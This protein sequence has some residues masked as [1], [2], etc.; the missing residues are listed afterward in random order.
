MPR[1]LSWLAAGFLAVSA[2]ISVIGAGAYVSLAGIIEAREID[3]LEAVADLKDQQIENWLQERIG[4]AKVIVND[5]FL[6]AAIGR[7]FS[8]TLDAA[9][10]RLLVQRLDVFREIYGYASI[11]LFDAA[12]LRRFSSG[13][14]RHDNLAAAHSEAM[15]QALARPLIQLIDFHRGEVADQAGIFFSLATALRSDGNPPGQAMGVLLLNIDPNSFLFPT[16]QS[17]PGSNKTGEALLVRREGEEVVFINHL[18][19]H[20]AQPLTL[21]LPARLDL[22]ATKALNGATGWVNGKDYRGVPVTAALRQIAATP[23]SL[24]V[25]VDDEEIFHDVRLLAGATIGAVLF[26]IVGTAIFVVLLWR[27]QRLADVLA[28]TEKDSVF[29]SVIDNA[30]DA[31]CIAAPD[32]HY[33]YANKEAT[34][35]LGYSQAELLVMRVGDITPAADRAHALSRFADLKQRGHMRSESVLEHKD[36]QLIPVDINSVALPDQKLFVSF[37]NMSERKALEQR[38]HE[39]RDFVAAV[40]QATASVIVVLDRRGRIVR[41]NHAAEEITGFTMDELRDRSIWDHLIPVERRADVRRVFDNLMHDRLIGFYENDWICKDGARRL[42]AWRNTV[43]HDAAGEVSHVVALG[44][45]IT[46]RRAN[47]L[48]MQ[49]DREQQA[50][51]RELLENV[52]RGGSLHDVLMSSLRQVMTISWLALLPKGGVFL[53]DAADGVLHLKV[54]HNLDP[55]LHELCAQLTPGHCLCGRVAVSGKTEFASHVDARHEVAFPGMTDH[56][57]YAVPLLSS[58]QVLGVLILYLPAGLRPDPMKEEFLTSVAGILATFVERKAVERELEG[59]RLQ[60]EDKVERRTIEL[61]TN[62]AR[63]GAILKTM[64]DGVIQIDATGTIQEVNAAITRMFGYAEEELTG[65]NVTL[66]IPEQY[67]ARHEYHLRH[68]DGTRHSKV[69]G[70]R[71]EVEGLRKDG[72]V[73]PLELTTNALTDS[74]G[75]AFIGIV[76]DITRQKSA[77]AAREAARAD[78]E[79]LARTKSEFLAN[80]SH[81]IRTPLNAILGLAQIGAHRGDLH[82]A[83]ETFERILGAGQNLLGIINDVLDFSKIEAGKLAIETQPFALAEAIEAAVDLV[84]KRAEAKGLAL[85]I[86]LAADLPCW[87]SGDKLRFEQILVNL[88]SNAVKFTERGEIRVGAQRVG[89][90]RLQF[91][92]ADTGI[93]MST[94]QC[95]RLFTPF[96]QADG[97]TTR[98]FG[99]TGLGLAISRDLAHLMGGDIAVE[100]RPDAGSVFSLRLRL[101]EAAAVAA[102]VRP[103]HAYQAG[104]RLPGLRVLAAEDVELNRIVLEDFLAREGAQVTFATNG[105]EA[106]DLVETQGGA[107]FDIV[108]M[109]IQMPVMDGYAATGHLRTLAPDLPVIGLTAHAL[110]EERAHCLAAGMVAH[111]TKPIDLDMLVAA[112]RRHVRPEALGPVPAGSGAHAA[113]AQ[114][115]GDRAGRRP[116]APLDIDALLLRYKGRH[117]FIERLLQT[118]RASQADV[119]D[120][121]R[122]A[123]RADDRETVAFIAHG[124]KGVAGNIEAV[125]LRECADAVERLA[126]A[127]AADGAEPIAAPAERLA[128]GVAALLSFIDART[129]HRGG[130]DTATGES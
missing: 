103:P 129:E 9:S 35:L 7:L 81:E 41:F 119:P 93:G 100:S 92:V 16:I 57:H 117:A 33:T 25:K 121:L 11:E 23:W 128:D 10:R 40:L 2:I 71:L 122:V 87:V 96:E 108:L 46:E 102:A 82:K 126:R 75:R 67:R 94:E 28:M 130:S 123:A 39:E 52:L 78:A 66:L 38:I 115:A 77:D 59:Y 24:V 98:R 22:P 53:K 32:G 63:T 15:K 65:R 109:D 95:A 62:M 42:F 88:L 120:R 54:E 19:H 84:A 80:M 124:L 72:S 55:E 26:V 3:R 14:A 18:R 20:Q 83:G 58:G 76:R 74:A 104:P 12:G 105:R 110:A 89:D 44:D 64:M 106:L 107:A 127:D 60:L 37:R 21:R 56:G 27:Q 31:V 114:D 43:L 90:D 29:R 113:A 49:Q 34:K 48:R 111:V 69:I 112:I 85:R 36:G 99:G 73:F 61:A 47:E 118:V 101:P 91:Q 45:D 50:V 79:R 125:G 86:E 30:A 116:D 51:L 6:I 97:S 1:S 17:W 5:P 13:E 70:Q 4:D 68:H 8:G